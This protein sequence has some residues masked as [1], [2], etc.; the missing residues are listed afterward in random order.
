MRRL[1]RSVAKYRMKLAGVRKV[2]KCISRYWLDFLYPKKNMGR[3]R[4]RRV[5]RS[6]GGDIYL[7]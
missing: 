1:K 6:S 3:R 4:R 7:P 5:A 2:N